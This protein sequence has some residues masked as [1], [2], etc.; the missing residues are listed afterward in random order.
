MKTSLSFDIINTYNCNTLAILDTSYYNPN[1]DVE[2]RTLQIITPFDDEVRESTYQK[3][4][5]T[6]INS[7]F[8]GVTSNAPEELLIAIPDGLYTIKIT[9]CPYDKYYK[10][11]T[12]YRT[13][14]LECKYFKA[15]L[16]LDFNRCSSCFDTSQVKKLDTA[17]RYIDGVIANSENCNY[18]KATELYKYANKLLDEILDCKDCD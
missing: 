18:N 1:M 17:K 5:V 12:F 15:I 9:I 16:T 8:I 13:C 2:G 11:K 10:E 3:N 6:Y 7:N 14:Q 4:G